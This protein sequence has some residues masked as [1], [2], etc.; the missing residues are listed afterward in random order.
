MKYL[1]QFESNE[2]ELWLVVFEDP[3]SASDSHQNLFHEE[4]SAKNFYLKL[5]NDEIEKKL[6]FRNIDLTAENMVLT[7][8]EADEW[9]DENTNCR[10][11]F[12]KTIVQP[13]FELP[14]NIKYARETRKYNL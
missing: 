1:K 14:E 7:I 10:I 4:E 8:E 9:M 3:D 5:I 11:Y 6:A 2:D 12:Y 13:K